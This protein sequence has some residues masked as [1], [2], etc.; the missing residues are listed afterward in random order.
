VRT[1]GQRNGTATGAGRPAPTGSGTPGVLI[2]DD[3][4]AHKKQAE[5]IH[6]EISFRARNSS[7]TDLP[8]RNFSGSAC[9]SGALAKDREAGGF[10]VVG[11]RDRGTRPESG[12]VAEPPATPSATGQ[13]S[14]LPPSPLRW[15]EAA[16]SFRSFFHPESLS[17]TR[18]KRSRLQLPYPERARHDALVG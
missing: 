4:Q 2:H 18:L 1:R 11:S 6:A 15:Q 3:T 8:P 13:G 9:G 14:Q 5:N 7:V 12:H 17:T 16:Y 10:E